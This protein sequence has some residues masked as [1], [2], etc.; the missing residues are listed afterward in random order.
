[1]LAGGLAFVW[2]AVKRTHW[3]PGSSDFIR[4]KG[5]MWLQKKHWVISGRSCPIS[6][7]ASDSSGC[8]SL[9]LPRRDPEAGS[10]RRICSPFPSLLRDQRTS[11]IVGVVLCKSLQQRPSLVLNSWTSERGL[12]FTAWHFFNPDDILRTAD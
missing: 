9:E 6:E 1:M 12:L 7:M 11:G 10:P 3:M 8:N 5:I 2:V 4:N